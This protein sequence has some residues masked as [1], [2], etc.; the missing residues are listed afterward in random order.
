MC[1]IKFINP[2]QKDLYEF[3]DDPDVSMTIVEAGGSAIESTGMQAAHAARFQSGRTGVVEGFK[4]VF[5]Q[6]PDGRIQN[7]SSISAGM[8]YPGVGPQVAY[9]VSSGRV[10]AAYALDSEVLDAYELL[11]RSEGVFAAL[12]SAHALVEAIKIAK[13][14]SPEQSVIFN[15]SGRGDKDLFIVSKKFNFDLNE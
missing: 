13:D 14:M 4:S 10:S 11:A 8:D 2:Y 7:T 15:M 5:M 1:D 9:L 3:L 6:T 12:E